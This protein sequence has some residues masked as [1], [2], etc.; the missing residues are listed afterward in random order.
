[1]PHSKDAAAIVRA[2]AALG[3]SLGMTTVAEGVERPD[4]LARL[5]NEGCAEVQ[6]FLF[7][8]PRPTRNIPEL[9]KR[10]HRAPEAADALL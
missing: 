2:I 4:Q 7:S 3:A 6:G 1:M 9:L 10:F 5:R 8:I